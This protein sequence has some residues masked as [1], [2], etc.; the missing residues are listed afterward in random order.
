MST[1]HSTFISEFSVD[2]H[3]LEVAPK[4]WDGT[5]EIGNI[6]AGEIGVA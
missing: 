4:L 2:T 3:K 6:P 1:V 5:T